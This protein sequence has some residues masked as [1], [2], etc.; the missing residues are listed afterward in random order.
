VH[1]NSV[2]SKSYNVSS[3]VI[4]G[5]VLGPLLF[6][7]FMSD[8]ANCVSSPLIMYADDS[9]LYRVINDYNDE[10]LLQNDL[11]SI[12]LWCINNGMKINETKCVFMD[13]TLSKFRRFGRYFINDFAIPHAEYVK[14]LGVF[15]AF[16]LSWNHHV[17]YIRAKCARLLGFIHRNMKECTPRVKC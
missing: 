1:F 10:V 2:F 13:V 15:I 3:G 5:S 11:N 17:K 9:T 16:D 8:L 6:N 7:I 12:Q 14:M 4:Q